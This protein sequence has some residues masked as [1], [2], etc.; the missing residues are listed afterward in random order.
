[1]IKDVL[2]ET[3]RKIVKEEFKAY[4]KVVNEIIKSNLKITNKHLD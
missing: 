1:M 4:E 3:I 2:A